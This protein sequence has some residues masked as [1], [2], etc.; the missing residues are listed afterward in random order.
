MTRENIGTKNRHVT[1]DDV[2]DAK[3]MNTTSSYITLARA[4][5]K[6]FPLST[7]TPTTNLISNNQDQGQ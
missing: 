1:N 5:M 4:Q 2:V 6:N 3:M 7:L